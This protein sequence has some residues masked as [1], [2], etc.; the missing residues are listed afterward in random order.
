MQILEAAG[1]QKRTAYL[2]DLRQVM[3]GFLTDGGYWLAVIHSSVGVV[4]LELGRRYEGHPEDF[5]LATWGCNDEDF[6]IVSMA[7][8]RLTRRQYADLLSEAGATIDD[9]ALDDPVLL[10]APPSLMGEGIALASV[11]L[12]DEVDNDLAMAE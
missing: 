1:Y 4:L 7:K 11:I 8:S 2:P 10:I 9:S 12:C 6:A 3:R 5:T